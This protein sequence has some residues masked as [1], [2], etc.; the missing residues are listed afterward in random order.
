MCNFD[1]NGLTFI[2][3]ELN[4]QIK[5]CLN[6]RN[7]SD[8]Q[9]LANALSFVKKHDIK[10]DGNCCSRVY[11]RLEDL[12]KLDE[13]PAYKLNDMAKTLKESL[14]CTSNQ[15]PS[16]CNLGNMAPDSTDGSIWDW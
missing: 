10:L 15:E 1:N 5:P 16:F 4:R 7:I 9:L 14:T 13:T 8:A 3:H 11:T 12:E 2:F 6:L